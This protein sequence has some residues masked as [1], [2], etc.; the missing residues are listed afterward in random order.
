MLPETDVWLPDIRIVGNKPAG[1]SSDSKDVRTTCPVRL[2]SCA[3]RAFSNPFKQPQDV[4]VEANNSPPK[5]QGAFPYPFPNMYCRKAD[6]RLAEDRI[7][8]ELAPDATIW[9][10]YQEESREYDNELIDSRNKNL[11]MMLLF[12]SYP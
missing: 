10:L 12:V 7:G 11:D 6:E 9:E 4:K 2:L 3:N 5:Y 8:E 1:S